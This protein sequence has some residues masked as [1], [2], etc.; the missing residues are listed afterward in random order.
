M[1]LF[2]P[3]LFM[4]WWLI[5]WHHN[6]SVSTKLS[7]FLSTL[8]GPATSLQQ[9]IHFKIIFLPWIPCGWEENQITHQSVNITLSPLASWYPVFCLGLQISCLKTKWIGH[10]VVC[11][12]KLLFEQT[13]SINSL[14]RTMNMSIFCV[15]VLGWSFFPYWEWWLK[16]RN[17]AI[18]TLL[19]QQKYRNISWGTAHFRTVSSSMWKSIQEAI[20]FPWQPEPRR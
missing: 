1:H 20:S 10:I 6:L 9:C 7:G 5:S 3:C 11:I 19:H 12:F 4:A 14:R 15:F 2:P 8:P 18:W 17:Y 16:L 13:L